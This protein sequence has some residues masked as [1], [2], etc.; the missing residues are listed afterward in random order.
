MPTISQLQRAA[1][2]AAK[3]AQQAAKNALHEAERLAKVARKTATS[4]TARRKLQRDLQN[5]VKMLGAA[6]RAAV[7]AGSKAAAREMRAGKRPKRKA[8]PKPRPRAKARARRA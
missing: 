4:P 5:T 1:M 3:R 2:H 6:G 8:L 7:L